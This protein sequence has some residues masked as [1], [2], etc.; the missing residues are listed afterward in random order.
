MKKEETKLKFFN[1]TAMIAV[2]ILLIILLAVI[3]VW[4]GNKN[5]TQAV[6]SMLSQVEFRGEYRIGDGEWQEIEK[7]KHISSTKGDVTL[8]GNF[9]AFTP[10]NE[11]VGIYMDEIPVVF[12]VNHIKLTFFVDGNPYVI[13]HENPLFGKSS[14]GETWYV[15]DLTVSDITNSENLV[16]IVIH[17]PHSF[18]NENAIDEMLTN[19][20]LWDGVRTEKDLLAT[21]QSQRNM[22]LFFVIASVM[23]LGTALFSSLIHVKNSKLIWLLGL[24]ILFAGLYL[25]YNSFGISFWSESIFSNTSISLPISQ[26]VL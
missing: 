17:N 14:C 10:N 9:H 16:E 11:Y 1:K 18:G 24:I 15:P 20:A 19:I 5:S 13:E 3:L 21:G 22:G 23:F 12:Y 4:N 2:G 7:G 8:R 25:T 26:Y 6:P